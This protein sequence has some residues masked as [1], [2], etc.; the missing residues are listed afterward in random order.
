MFKMIYKDSAK[1]KKKLKK[2]IEKKKIVIPLIIFDLTHKP[3][4]SLSEIDSVCSVLLSP[5]QTCC[6]SMENIA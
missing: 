1:T 4:C 6:S 2:N 3:F 5:G